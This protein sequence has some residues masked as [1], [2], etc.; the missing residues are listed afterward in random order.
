MRQFF[1]AAAALVVLAGVVLGAWLLLGSAFGGG[2][3]GGA[4]ERE[5]GPEPGEDPG[6]TAAAYAAAWTAGDYLT[7]AALVREPPPTF[8]AVHQQLRDGLEATQ[9]TVEA[10]TAVEDVDGRA[11]VPLRV[12]VMLP[13]DG[14][15]PVSWEVELAVLRDRG[16]WGVEWDLASV[17]PELRDGLIFDM[18][19]A[20]VERSPILA[21]DGTPLAGSGTRVTF[22]F[23]P[24]SVFDPEAVVEAFETALPGS[25][26]TAERLLARDDLVD[27]WFYPVVTV[28]EQLADAVSP[29]LREAGGIL[30][31]TESGRTLYADDFAVHIVGRVDEATAE[32]LERLGEPYV[33]GDR[34]G[35]F[36]LEREF[37]QE[38]TGSDEISAV[39]RDRSDNAVRVELATFQERPSGP[40]ETTLDITVQ[41]AVER[42]LVGVEDTVAIVVVDATSGAIR[43]SASRPLGGFNRAFEG[44]YPPGSAFK[45]VTAEALLADGLSPDDAVACPGD[46]VV[47]GLAVTN[48]GTLA[49][50]TTS[51]TTSFAQ[52]CNTT[53]ARMGADLGPDAMQAAAERFGFNLEPISPLPAAGGSFPQ[54]GDTA[55][56]AAASFGQARVTAS[57]LHLASIAAATVTGVWH[58]P[59]LLVADGPGESRQLSGGVTAGL[60]TLMRAVVTDG[61][62]VA[63]DVEVEGALPVYGKTGTAQTDDG[64]EHAW[65]VGTYGE[66]GFAV[67]VEAGGSGGEVAAPLAARFIEAL[68][69]IERGD[70]AL[71]DLG[72]LGPDDLDADEFDLDLGDLDLDEFNAD[73]SSGDGAAEDG[74]AEDGADPDDNTS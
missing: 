58:Q 18:D 32:D 9:V 4:G 16:Q 42:A 64:V 7:M 21:A 44:R 13:Y 68:I 45:I 12:E 37:E 8:T 52:S 33:A 69:A 43:A 56:L 53:F 46:E 39:L 22:G 27:G 60:Q 65:F 25:G 31:Q 71:L 3:S 29:T 70:D 30:R 11:T 10:G 28:S 51:L 35:R 57:P 40:I 47:G 15:E 41:Q 19:I 2:G 55:E 73:G 6:A 54:P 61:S 38:L 63:A 36:G 26:A 17:H 49:L 24:A 67:L 72:D 20:P 74:A 66:L 48:A 23:E 34:V 59:F 1:A 50:G 14:V 62:G 5:Q